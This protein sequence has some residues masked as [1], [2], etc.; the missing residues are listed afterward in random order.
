M[1]GSRCKLARPVVMRM[2]ECVSFWVSEALRCFLWPFKIPTVFDR[3]LSSA[4]GERAQLGDGDEYIVYMS[5]CPWLRDTAFANPSSL[6]SPTRAMSCRM[7]KQA[8]KFPY[9]ERKALTWW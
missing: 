9:V 7:E 2:L 6:H 1:N 4:L 5:I 3:F 8:T